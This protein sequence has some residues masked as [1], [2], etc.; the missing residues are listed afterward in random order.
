MRVRSLLAVLGAAS[1]L[2]T[3]ATAGS[4]ISTTC[5]TGLVIVSPVTIGVEVENSGDNTK[6][7][8]CYSDKPAGTPG[9]VGGKMLVDVWRNTGST[10]GVY[11]AVSCWYDG[12]PISCYA[13]GAVVSANVTPGD[14]GVSGA[15]ALHV[16]SSCA[17]PVPFGTVTLDGDPTRPL[18]S[19]HVLGET[20]TLDVPIRCVSPEPC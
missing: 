7:W 9:F 10:P 8:I 13:S 20:V 3:P 19:V 4:G 1:L 17:L 18:V 11:A 14:L 16:G 5:T 2:A 6:I 12:H 15:C